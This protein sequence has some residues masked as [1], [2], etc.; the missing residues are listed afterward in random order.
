[1]SIEKWNERYRACKHLSDT[2]EPL[3]ERFV[4]DLAPGTALD[5]ACGP[6]RNTLFLAEHGWHV[7]AVD[8]SPIAIAKLRR[9]FGYIDARVA[10]LERGEFQIQP[11]SYDLICDCLYLQR[12]LFPQIKA[13]TRTGGVAIVTVLLGDAATPTRVC[14]GELRGYFEDWKILHYREEAVAELVAVR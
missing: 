6:G 2:P 4:A 8:G 9:R 3:V 14:P 7:T 1:M 5:L 12:D 10:D 11:D 13:G